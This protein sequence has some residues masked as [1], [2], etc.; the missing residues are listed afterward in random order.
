MYPVLFKMPGLGWEV[1][2][3]GVALMVAYLGSIMW[4]AQRAQKSG[5]N[6]DVVLNCGF[7]A[8]IGGVVGSRA[9][10]VYQFWNEQF[11]SAGSPAAIFWRVIDVR[12]GGLVVYGGVIMVLIVML[13]YLWL[14]RHSIRWYLDI[15]APS[16]ALGMALGRIGCFLNGCCWGGVA[17]LPWAVTFPYGSP[18]ALRQWDNMVPGAGV[19][20]ELI[21]FSPKGML[22]NG[23]AALPLS[24]EMLRATGPELDAARKTV[25][26]VTV[27]VRALEAQLDAGPES[28]AERGRI[29]AQID[30]L[31]R[32]H[33]A[34]VGKYLA[35]VTQMKKYDLTG[36]QIT[37]IARP[38]RSVP[39]HPTQLYATGVLLL[40]ALLL[41]ALYWRRTW[42]GQVIC[43]LFIL[44]PPTRY[45]IEI[46]RAD[47][48]LDTLGF[49]ISQFTALCL[50][51]I[52]ILAF[53]ALR[54]LPRRSPRATVWTPPPAEAKKAAA[55]SA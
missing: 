8:L 41:N 30:A 7:L 45:L 18:P 28:A 21:Y 47:N 15:I 37:A 14:W 33:A 40:L 54:S 29:Q 39:V 42:D 46:I 48:P 11:A 34:T 26:D 25:E 19:P 38:L 4:A 6:P 27:R 5:A 9:L 24:R 1:P 53:V 31:E 3:Y 51:A 22:P 55:G 49:T 43:A 50:S 13:G 32:E 20:E 10:F 36:D 52:G 35:V 2:G 16:A 44:E 17:D 23:A 12:Q